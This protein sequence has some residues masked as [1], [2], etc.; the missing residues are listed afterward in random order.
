MG[1]E[2]I[3]E[4]LSDQE[5]VR[6]EKVKKLQELGID[7]FGQAF[8]VT[9]KS[10]DIKE[11]YKGYTHEELEAMNVEVSVAGRIM[12]IRKMGKASFFAI[13]DIKG[14]QQANLTH[15][16]VGAK[17]RQ[18]IKELGGTMPEDLP[19]VESIKSVERKQQKLFKSKN[20]D[21]KE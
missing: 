8:E 13:Q 10:S 1:N 4:K 3:R 5:I 20:E 7:P 9:A 6:R 18:T 12:F 15:Y 19:T 16:E 21:S 2:I 17:V 11:K 14:K